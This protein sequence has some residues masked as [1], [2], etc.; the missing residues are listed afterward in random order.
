LLTV[1]ERPT[2]VAAH[3]ELAALR[4]RA[5]RAHPALPRPV[6]HVWS[7]ENVLVL[8]RAGDPWVVGPITRDPLACGGRTVIP[9]GPRRRLA[10]VSDVPFQHVAIAHQ[11][12]PDGPV[13]G[14]LPMLRGGSRTCTD[15]V[16]RA[17]AGTV[18][19]GPGT[20]RVLRAVDGLVRGGRRATAAGADVLLDPLVFGIL[21]PTTPAHG[22]P[23]LWYPLAAWVW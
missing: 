18:P 6:V 1:D 4:A 14:L 23:C 8:D 19:P 21:G 16:A 11:L 13:A 22:Q 10:A 9:R 20:T 12:D 5:A 7:D 17:V 15:E 3:P 2:L